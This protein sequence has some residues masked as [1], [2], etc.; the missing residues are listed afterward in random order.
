MEIAVVLGRPKPRFPSDVLPGLLCSRTGAYLL[1][2]SVTLLKA[3]Y[4]LFIIYH[5]PSVLNDAISFIKTG[6]SGKAKRQET[7]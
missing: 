2:S 7:V 4:T 6:E 1:A 3:V 5:K